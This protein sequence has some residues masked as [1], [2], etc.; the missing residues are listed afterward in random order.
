MKTTFVAIVVLC[1]AS[2]PILAESA[3]DMGFSAGGGP[4]PA[5]LFL[6]LD[7]LNTAVTHAGYPQISQVLFV[8]GGAGYGSISDD[9]RIG[10]VGLSGDTTSI[11]GSRSVSLT[12]GYGGATIEKAA[13]TEDDYTILLGTML[14]YGNLDLRFIRDVPDSFDD[15]VAQPFLSSMTKGFYVVQPYVAFESKPLSWIWMRFQLGFL[16]SLPE[17]WSFEDTEFSGPPHTMTGLSVSAMIRFGGGWVSSD[18][19]EEDQQEATQTPMES[20]TE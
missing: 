2:I 12:M 15:A 19:P 20:G 1:I 18:T 14:G 11:S 3:S 13:V 16:W 7:D 9:L 10:G 5:L 8:M 4:M 17:N 6:D